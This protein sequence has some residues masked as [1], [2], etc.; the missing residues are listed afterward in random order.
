MAK[1]ILITPEF[2]FLLI[3]TVSIHLVSGRGADRCT[4]RLRFINLFKISRLCSLTNNVRLRVEFIHTKL[5]NLGSKS[6]QEN[7][8]VNQIPKTSY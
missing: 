2:F 3:I 8:F 4:S 6:L 7:R 1:D 5:V